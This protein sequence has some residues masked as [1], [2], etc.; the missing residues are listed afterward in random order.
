MGHV[1][2]SVPLYNPLVFITLYKLLRCTCLHCFKFRMGGGEIERYRR[3]LELLSQG[4]LQEAQALTVGSSAAA[5]RTGGEMIDE[6]MNDEDVDDGGVGKAGRDYDVSAAVKGSAA[7]ALS[8]LGPRN[9]HVLTSQTLEATIGTVGDFFRKQP[10]GKC[11]N[12]G[13]HNPGIKRE[14]YGKLF[15]MPLPAKKSAANSVQGTPIMSV[16]QRIVDSANAVAEMEEEL[17]AGIKAKD[18]ER[19]QKRAEKMGMEGEEDE[20][21]DDAMDLDEKDD[22]KIATGVKS[23]EEESDDED[24]DEDEKKETQGAGVNKAGSRPSAAAELSGDTPKYLTPTEVREIL[25]RVWDVNEAILAYIYPADVARRQRKRPN[26]TVAGS[27]AAG[28]LAARRGQGYKDFFVQTIAVAP[29]R[30][31]PVNRVGDIVYEHPQNTLLVKL[32]NGNMDL[33]AASRGEAPMILG[34]G[35]AAE[36]AA[37]AAAA[38]AADP[39]AQ[40]GRTLRVWLDMQNSLNALIDSSAADDTHGVMGIKQMLEKKEG[41]FRKNMMG[42]RVNF[43]ARSV[44]SP[45]VYLNG[46]E[47]GVP[48]YFASRLSFPERVTP[49]NVER[50]REAVVAGPGRNPG[51]VAVEDEK[52][53]L[54]MLRKDKKS[55]EAVAKT[56]YA[57]IGAGGS[58]AGTPAGGI[59]IVTPG[60][61]GKTAGA[62]TARAA[63]RYGGG[64][65]V[66]RTM[67]DGDFMLTNRQPTLHKPGM[68]G[69]RA[70]IMRGTRE[71]F[72]FFF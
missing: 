18:A 60:K 54:V 56:L 11:Q 5:K 51:A 27:A 1:D 50:L 12:C 66:Y 70:R 31:R 58:G 71:C 48:P 14:G 16:L 32:I 65:I 21:K 52:G 24:E 49:W 35:P 25:R 47:I 38:F 3:R 36:A 37:A 55:R 29:N 8:G 68:M 53:R 4:R 17:A 40:L 44:I 28:N 72:F 19:K 41:L 63:A 2:L 34:R 39:Q 20:D 69:H 9:P 6:A 57:N 10:N 13:A 59:P 61:S 15:A 45:D 33:V 22:S 67:V 23:D 43:A 64:K 30:Y 62:V 26:S 7:R 46:G 42:K